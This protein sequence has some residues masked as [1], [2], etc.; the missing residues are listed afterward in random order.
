MMHGVITYTN[1]AINVLPERIV[2]NVRSAML[3]LRN[4]GSD[5]IQLFRA[6]LSLKIARSFSTGV[7]EFCPA[8]TVPLTEAILVLMIYGI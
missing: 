6:V 4:I 2:D 7:V 5:T 8:L 3:L 1:H